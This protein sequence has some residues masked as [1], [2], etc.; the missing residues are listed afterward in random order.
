MDTAAINQHLFNEAVDLYFKQSKPALAIEK[1]NQILD[2]DRNSLVYSF[3]A[4]ILKDIGK[5]DDALKTIDEGLGHDLKSHVLLQLK[6][7]ILAFNY[8]HLPADQTAT[9]LQQALSCVNQAL[10]YFEESNQTMKDIMKTL[11]DYPDYLNSYIGTKVDLKTLE[12]NIRNLIGSVYVLSRVNNVEKQ[13][14]GERIRT[15]EL[16]GVFTAIMAF[17]FSSVQIITKIGAAEA[18][19]LLVGVALMLISFLLALHMVLDPNARRRY[20]YIL[21]TIQI[22]VLLVLPWYVKQLNVTKQLPTQS[23]PVIQKAFELNK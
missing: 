9:F 15:I 20:L 3:K 5:P 13:L 22:V 2:T 19:V 23:E 12:T 14:E 10:M 18:L 6:A 1:L 17:I 4:R 7:E 16:L 11:P 21:L 8:L